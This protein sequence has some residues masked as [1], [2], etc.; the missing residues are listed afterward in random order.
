MTLSQGQRVVSPAGS[1]Q[2]NPVLEVAPELATAV[3]YVALGPEV[4]LK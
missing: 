4:K 1:I 2:E 3:R